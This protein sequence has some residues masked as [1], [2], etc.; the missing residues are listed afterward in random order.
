MMV[1]SGSIYIYMN[2]GY[3]REYI[4]IYDGYIIMAVSGNTYI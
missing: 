4:Y 1:I 3:I 2:D